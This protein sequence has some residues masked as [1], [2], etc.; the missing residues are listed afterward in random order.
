MKKLEFGNYTLKFGE[1]KVLLDCYEDVVLP[2]FME[3]RHI[4]KFKDVSEFFFIDTQV[5]KL[6]DDD[7]EPVI[8]ITGRIVKNTKLK[9]EQIFR[10]DEI[11]E[12]ISELE[13]APSS[14]FLLILN[15]H[16]LILCKEVPGAPTI[17]NFESTSSYFLKKEYI[18][19]IDTQHSTFEEARKNNPD[20][21]RVTKAS[22]RIET[23]HPK[24]RITPLSNK[25]DLLD[26]VNR[27]K[28][29][30]SVSITLLPT[31]KE[32]IDNDDFW[33]DLS[34]R[35][36]EMNSSSAKVSF[37]NNK[38]GL[39]SS[40]VYKQAN[41]ASS[42]GNSEI[43]LKGSD[44]EGDTIRGSNEDFSLS[45]ELGDISRNPIRSAKRKFEL[46]MSLA[47]NGSISLPKLSQEVTDRI[48]V[49]FN[50]L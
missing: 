35:R 21:P 13:T 23:P 33:S 47:D 39:D 30:D 27:F 46:F 38:D 15:N 26:F 40:S 42:L 18:N 20:L 16:R 17:K 48:K 5:I 31:N 36:E 29:I 41:S 19:Y 44:N 8:G 34:S 9:R 24:L 49:I 3:M 2:S 25:E 10:E 4:R 28:K 6:N 45:I 22:L 43:K 32:E 11:V 12:D 1:N 37:T 50:R 7:K 14:T